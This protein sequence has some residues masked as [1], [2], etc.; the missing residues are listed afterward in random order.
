VRSIAISFCLLVSTSAFAEIPSASSGATESQCQNLVRDCFGSSGLA[1][2]NC[3]F[4]TSTHPSCE[5]T[6]LGRLTYSRW[7]SAPIPPS[8]GIE[9]GPAFLG[10][11]PIDH[12]CL[13][14]FDTSLVE[15]LRGQTLAQT[16]LQNLQN[17]LQECRQ[18]HPQEILR[19]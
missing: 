5:G 1:R 17:A 4:S 2:M 8:N 13:E 12:T 11:Q 9:N 7:S 16:D 19:P 10:P 18:V 6:D 15:K 14:R 3:L